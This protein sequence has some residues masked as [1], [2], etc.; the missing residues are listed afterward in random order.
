[1]NTFI[2]VLSSQGKARLLYDVTEIG[3][4]AIQLLATF[5]AA[6]TPSPW[7]RSIL[8]V[9]KTCSSLFQTTKRTLSNVRWVLQ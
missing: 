8:H 9:K 6:S 1:M 5:L 4:L 2:R 7:P 3:I